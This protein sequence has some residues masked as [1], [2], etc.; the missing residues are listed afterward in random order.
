M[1]FYILKE[2]DTMNPIIVLQKVVNG[3]KGLGALKA[4][5]DGIKDEFDTIFNDK[6]DNYR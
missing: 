3:I 5:L 6:T 2:K 1:Y 4:A